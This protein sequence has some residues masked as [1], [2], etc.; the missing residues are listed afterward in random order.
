MFPTMSSKRLY[1]LAYVAKEAA[2]SSGRD[3]AET[4]IFN[5]I[6]MTIPFF[7]TEII[8]ELM[9]RLNAKVDH[10]K[11]TRQQGL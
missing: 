2:V 8:A 3:S 4:K 5:T 7:T 1:D 11:A 10:V 6:I 9:E